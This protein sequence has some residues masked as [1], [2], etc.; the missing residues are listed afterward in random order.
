MLDDLGSTP[1]KAEASIWFRKNGKVYTYVA[2]YVNDLTL[3]MKDP[4]SLIK[5][6]K[7]PPYNLKF[8]GTEELSFQ[9]GCGFAS[10]PDGTLYM[11][12]SK[13]ITRMEE[14]HQRYFWELP[15]T[16]I[17]QP[18]EEGDHPKLDTSEFL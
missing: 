15:S 13:Y 2:K 4:L 8:K 11:E 3:V 6:L 7:Q 5:Q 16:K 17:K 1:Y 18:L 12:A 9:L 10:D 14:S